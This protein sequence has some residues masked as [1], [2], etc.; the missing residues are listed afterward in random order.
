MTTVI[1]LALAAA[2]L[3]DTLRSRLI[4]AVSLAGFLCI[5]AAIVVD[6]VGQVTA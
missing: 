3:V 6:V 2:V 4:V 5:G 1:I